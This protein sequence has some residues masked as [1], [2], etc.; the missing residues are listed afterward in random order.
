MTDLE[1]LA[2]V[3]AVVGVVVLLF[4]LTRNRVEKFNV[5]IEPDAV[6]APVRALIDFVSIRVLLTLPKEITMD[7]S[8]DFFRHIQ[9]KVLPLTIHTLNRKLTL[10]VDFHGY[11]R[12][13]VVTGAE[14]ALFKGDA[15]ASDPGR[16]LS[17]VQVMGTLH[18]PE[19]KPSCSPR[20]NRS[21]DS[22]SEGCRSSD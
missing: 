20:D 5:H 14:S 18:D 17:D 3:V 22:Y 7:V 4:R 15:T 12:V 11:E 9:G 6:P 13:G 16:G 21:T 19:V 1:H 10:I 2:I 8:D